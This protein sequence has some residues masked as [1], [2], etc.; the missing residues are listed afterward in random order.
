MGPVPLPL[1][2]TSIYR[3]S[4]EPD[5]TCEPSREVLTFFFLEHVALAHEQAN[6]H[7]SKRQHKQLADA[8]S[9]T[10]GKTGWGNRFFTLLQAL[11]INHFKPS[12]LNAE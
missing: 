1:P 12:H 9:M 5:S 10:G 2:Y 7:Q 3:N 8:A 6:E 11:A 4:L